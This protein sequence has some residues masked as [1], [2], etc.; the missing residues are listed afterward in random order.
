MRQRRNAVGATARINAARAI[1]DHLRRTRQLRRGQHIGV[2][3]AFDGEID[4]LHVVRHAMRIGCV[5]YAPRIVSRRRR[6][7][8]FIEVDAGVAL[9][10]RRKS[11]G[12][13]I[14][15]PNRN[16]HRYIDPQLLDVVLVPVVAF[17]QCG[18]RLGFG[19]G[20]YDRKFAFKRHHRHRHPKL[21]GV[22]YEQQR[23]PR[24]IPGPWD[25]LLDAVVT[26]KGVQHFRHLERG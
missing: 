10:G 18:W 22:A 3:A 12:R 26:E 21:I 1:A 19:A 23:L 20:F 17:D 4:L 7:M 13:S 2:Y 9:I 5:I 24:Q 25:V 15:E 11:D 6:T 14:L 8:K 16:L